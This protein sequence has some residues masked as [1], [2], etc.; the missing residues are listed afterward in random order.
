MTNRTTDTSHCK[1]Y[2]RLL[3]WLKASF[4]QPRQRLFAATDATARQHGWQI[5]SLSGGLGRRYRDPRFDNL[6][7]CLQCRGS[8]ARVSGSPCQTCA[9]TGRVT[10]TVQTTDPPAPQRSA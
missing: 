1:I 2:L 10:L 3:A 7:S 9:G 4:D 5:I 6:A 8:G